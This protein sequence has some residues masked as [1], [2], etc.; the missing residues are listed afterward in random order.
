MSIKFAEI[1]DRAR[2]DGHV[3]CS[4]SANLY[5]DYRWGKIIEEC[6]GHKYHILL[7]ENFD[8]AIN[9]ILPFVHMKSWSFGNFFVSMP[10]FNYG[11][12]CADDDSVRDH[13]IDEAVRIAKDHKVQHIEFRQE[14]SLQ[15]G[16]PEKAIKVSMRLDLPGSPDELWKS[17]P[18][19]LRSQIKVPQKAGMI[20]RIGRVKNWIVFT[21][22]FLENMRHLGT[23]VYP[24]RFFRDILEAIPDKHLDM[25][26]LYAGYSRS[27][28]FSCRFQKPTRDSLGI[29]PPEA[30]SL[31]PEHAA[32]LVLPEIRLRERLYNIRFRQVNER[33]EHVQI[34]GAVGSGTHADD[35]ELLDSR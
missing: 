20:A 11:G 19:K 26:R 24:K 32:L 5:H 33:G 4:N 22:F 27:V 9:G 2:I 30:Q 34:Q 16:F 35:M 7:S 12:V 3:A 31:Q 17:F 1:Q 25:F 8:G 29:L 15:N 21:M 23:P 13:L 6:F 14:N 10:F 28:R 18:S